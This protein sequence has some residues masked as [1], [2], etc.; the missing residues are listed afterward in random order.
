[1]IVKGSRKREQWRWRLGIFLLVAFFFFFFL[2]FS[3][4]LSE[5]EDLSREDF[6]EDFLLEP[7]SEPDEAFALMLLW[8]KN[9]HLLPSLHPSGVGSSRQNGGCQK[10]HLSP[11]WHLPLRMKLQSFAPFLP[12]GDVPRFGCF[13]VLGD[14][15]RFLS[16]FPEEF[17]PLLRPSRPGVGLRV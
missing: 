11:F 8:C 1:M 7:L 13:L 16:P 14:L 15:S 5:P 4:S 10:S 3:L 2:S 17:D 6:L 12:D 9:T